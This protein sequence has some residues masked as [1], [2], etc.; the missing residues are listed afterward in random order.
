MS[1]IPCI[2][3]GRR[4][5]H[6][7]GEHDRQRHERR[8]AC[9]LL[10]RTWPRLA[11]LGRLLEHYAREAGPVKPAAPRVEWACRVLKSGAVVHVPID[12]EQ[13]L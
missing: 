12:P 7:A 13:V 4:R 3:C 5:G 6:D 2:V 1:G 10:R 8:R 9:N 11:G